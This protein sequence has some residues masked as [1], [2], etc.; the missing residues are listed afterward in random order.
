MSYH[1]KSAQS[2]SKLW[3]WPKSHWSFAAQTYRCSQATR[4]NVT[5]PVT[6]TTVSPVPQRQL[7]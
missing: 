4:K 7:N 5:V 3:V 1:E 2:S 6:W